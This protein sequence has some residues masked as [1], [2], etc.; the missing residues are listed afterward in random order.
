MNLFQI[1]QQF[2]KLCFKKDNFNI[3]FINY[4]YIKM[5]FSKYTFYEIPRKK[6]VFEKIVLHRGVTWVD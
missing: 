4:A 2:L 1:I 5:L 6:T 3:N